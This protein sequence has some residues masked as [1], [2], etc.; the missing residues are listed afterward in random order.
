[1]GTVL[2]VAQIA[3]ILGKKMSILESERPHLKIGLF[4]V[5]VHDA[6]EPHRA[7]KVRNVHLTESRFRCRPNQSDVRARGEKIG[8]LSNNLE[9]I[10]VHPCDS[11]HEHLYVIPLPAPQGGD[12]GFA[13]PLGEGYDV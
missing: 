5:F 6:R 8:L 12:S 1:M 10:L 3:V 9:T 11:L 7:R 4:N 2:F 13:W